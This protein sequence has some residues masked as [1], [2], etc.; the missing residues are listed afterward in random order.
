MEY[1]FDGIRLTLFEGGISLFVLANDDR[2][3]YEFAL[4]RMQGINEQLAVLGLEHETM[5]C[6]YGG[7]KFIDQIR[8]PVAKK[9][10]TEPADEETVK[11][12]SYELASGKYKAKHEPTVRDLETQ[13]AKAI[14]TGFV[15]GV[16]MVVTIKQPNDYVRRRITSI[17]AENGWEAE[18]EASSSEREGRYE[19]VTLSEAKHTEAKDP[20]SLKGLRDIINDTL[21]DNQG[22][23]DLKDILNQFLDSD[24]KS[25]AVAAMNDAA[26]KL[27]LPE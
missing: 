27:R 25:E 19:F 3:T 11:I 6:K 12:M 16:P 15:P 22:L 10:T 20:A 17:L 1:I 7:G 9:A 24:G 2:E 14:E 18:F 5:E 4:E 21:G 23:K 13:I 26:S 8:I